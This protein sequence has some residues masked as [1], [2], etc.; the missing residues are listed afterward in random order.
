MA[1]HQ[2]FTTATLARTRDVAADVRLFE[3]E[4][5][6]GVTP[7]QPGSHLDVEVL[8]DDKPQYRSFSLVGDASE[9]GR[10]RIAIKNRPNG[11]GG[12]RYLWSLQA[13]A[14][15]RVSEPKDRFPLS[16]RAPEVLLVA[17]GIGITPI[18]GMARALVRNKSNVRLLYTAR[19]RSQL[20]FVEELQQW[21]GDRLTLFVTEDNQR[22]DARKALANLDPQAELYICGPQSL[23]EDFLGQWLASGRPRD[24]FRFET[25]ASSG[26]FP[27]TPFDVRV[28]NRDVTLTVGREQSLLQALRA[29]GIDDILYDCEHGECGL[30]TIDVLDHTGDLDHRDVFYSARQKKSDKRMCACVSRIHNGRLTIDTSRHGVDTGRP[31]DQ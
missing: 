15:L 16:Y 30:C 7:H 25:F 8:V 22:L 18:Y 28:A 23:R 29:Q 3:I 24:R 21:L 11:H 31:D 12:S 2:Y 27:D 4:P 20:A 9:G 6:D 5:A 17:G 10:Y 26:R 13:G 14:R 19:S 1:T